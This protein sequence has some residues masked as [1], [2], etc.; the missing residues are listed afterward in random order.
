MLLNSSHEAPQCAPRA[1]AVDRCCFCASPTPLNIP[2]MGLRTGDVHACCFLAAHRWQDNSMRCL[3]V[4][5]N[6][7]KTLRQSDGCTDDRLSPTAPQKCPRCLDVRSPRVKSEVTDV[8][9]R[10]VQMVTDPRGELIRT[11]ALL[12]T[13]RRTLLLPLP[14]H[15]PSSTGAAAPNLYTSLASGLNKR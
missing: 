3:A 7:R 14:P 13:R 15:V 9:V 1:S 5:A 10:R 8:Q 2:A 12:H 11:G 6:D 4:L